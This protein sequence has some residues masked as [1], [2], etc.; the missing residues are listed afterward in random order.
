M[1]KNCVHFPGYVVM[2]GSPLR[3]LTRVP[4]GSQLEL[5]SLIDKYVKGF[6]D[7]LVSPKAK[8]ATERAGPAMAEERQWQQSSVEWDWQSLSL[9]CQGVGALIRRRKIFAQ[10]AKNE[11]FARSRAR[12]RVRTV[13][14]DLLA[15]RV[16]RGFAEKAN[17][18]S[19]RMLTHFWAICRTLQGFCSQLGHADDE[20]SVYMA[21][22]LEALREPLKGLEPIKGGHNVGLAGILKL[23]REITPSSLNEVRETLRIGCLC[24][25]QALSIKLGDTHPV[26]L[27]TW[28]SY[29]RYYDHHCL[30]K[31]P[32]RDSYKKALDKTEEK[33]GCDH[34]YTIEV[35]CDYAAAAQHIFRDDALSTSW[36]PS[37]GS[38][39]TKPVRV[40]LD[41]Q[42]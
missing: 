11:P 40:C 30:D 28:A 34:E 26:V 9:R 19:P 20:H 31:G 3:E 1:G 13:T 24:T 42:D 14:R 38:E 35:L 6:F 18:C 4:Y 27:K 7:A 12:D 21:E 23:L 39:R 15:D 5:L 16:F 22:F 8:T 29:Y 32:F 37:S 10:T 36:R 17:D 41:R 33:H 25:A 2:P